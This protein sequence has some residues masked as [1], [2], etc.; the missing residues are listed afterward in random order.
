MTTDDL[1]PLEES[2]RSCIQQHD[3]RLDS[4]LFNGGT[5]LALAAT[6]S[7][8]AVTWSG[9]LSWL[10]RALTGFAAFLI[11]LERA[12]NFGERWRYHR[13]RRDAYQSLLDRLNLARAVK[14]PKREELL[15]RLVDDLDRLR[16]SE[17][18]IPLGNGGSP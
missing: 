1:A 6:I 8:T 4:V 10:P 2:I 11:G 15:D 9:S 16:T 14:G 5:V 18:D 3:P 12:L 7:A 17:G 13:R